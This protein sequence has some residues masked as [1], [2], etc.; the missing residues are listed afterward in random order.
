MICTIY[1]NPTQRIRATSIIPVATVPKNEPV[2]QAIRKVGTAASRKTFSDEMAK[3]PSEQIN[4]GSNKAESTVAGTKLSQRTI[5]GA[6][7]RP[8]RSIIGTIL[9]I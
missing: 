5:Q 2:R 6:S 3:L 1:P 7:G 9:G 4:P 8:E